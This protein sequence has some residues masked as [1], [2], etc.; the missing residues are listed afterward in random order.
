MQRRCLSPRPQPAIGSSRRSQSPICSR[1][2]ARA[3]LSFGC[4]H[5]PDAAEEVEVLP[6]GQSFVEAAGFE[7]RAR[8]AAHLVALRDGVAVQ[9]G[10]APRRTGAAGPRGGGAWSV[11]PAPL[12]PIRPWTTPCGTREVQI[13]HSSDRSK[14]ARQAICTN[15]RFS[16]LL[17]LAGSMW[18][19]VSAYRCRGLHIQYTGAGGRGDRVTCPCLA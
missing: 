17:L 5:V 11:L 1:S 3:G 13:G 15:R 12:G 19:D 10:G 7:D 18:P 2:S 8:T 9:Y 16:H 4:G 6:G 14:G